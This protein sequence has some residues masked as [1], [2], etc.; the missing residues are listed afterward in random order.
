MKHKQFFVWTFCAMR[1]VFA[2]RFLFVCLSVGECSSFWEMTCWRVLAK[3]RR[4]VH[5]QNT[6]MS[7]NRFDFEFVLHTTGSTHWTHG[8]SFFSFRDGDCFWCFVERNGQFSLFFCCFGNESI[9]WLHVE[10]CATASQNS[11]MLV[12][13]GILGNSLVG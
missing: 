9:L 6:C 1:L 2:V 10:T 5:F 13:S 8:N 11:G 7:V 12:A 4:Q 3:P